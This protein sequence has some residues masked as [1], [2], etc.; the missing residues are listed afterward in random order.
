MYSRI[1]LNLIFNLSFPIYYGELNP[2]YTSI[3]RDG[4]PLKAVISLNRW[5]TRVLS[6]KL[7]GI[8]L[9]MEVTR[10]YSRI[11]IKRSALKIENCKV[12]AKKLGVNS[13][14]FSIAICNR[15]NINLPGYILIKILMR[16]ISY[17]NLYSRIL[18]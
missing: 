2:C 5:R 15:I 16:N 4:K 7:N 12:I 11:R 18:C 13:F 1:Y 10:G 3:C 14:R 6:K 8:S 9:N 17:S